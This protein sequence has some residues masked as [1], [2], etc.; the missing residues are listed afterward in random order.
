MADMNK[1]KAE[2]AEQM[3]DLQAKLDEALGRVDELT[4]ERDAAVQELAEAGDGGVDE[5]VADLEA[6]LA[7]AEKAKGALEAKITDLELGAGDDGDE[8]ARQLRE[9]VELLEADNQALKI[10]RDEERNRAIRLQAQMDEAGSLHG[11]IDNL[12]PVV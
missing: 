12:P 6:K 5:R 3:D 7:E 11:R 10:S 2:L 1:T 9:K 4:T 8:E